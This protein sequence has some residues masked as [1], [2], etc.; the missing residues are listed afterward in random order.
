M[1]VWN[2]FKT[3]L[4]LHLQLFQQHTQVLL[5][6]AALESEIPTRRILNHGYAGKIGDPNNYQIGLTN[7]L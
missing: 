5:L 4:P 7:V 3:G 2:M 1:Q 6:E